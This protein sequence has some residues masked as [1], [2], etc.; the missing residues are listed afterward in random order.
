MG[1]KIDERLP[2]DFGLKV[3]PGHASVKSPWE[4][5]YGFRETVHYSCR[6]DSVVSALIMQAFRI[7]LPDYMER[8]EFMCDA[9]HNTQLA[10]NPSFLE[11]THT[12]PFFRGNFT[13]ALPADCG[14]ENSLMCGRVNDFGS[15]RVEKELDVCD[16]DIVGTEICRSTIYGMQGGSDACAEHFKAGPKLEFHMVE[17]KGCGDRHCRVVAESREKWPMPKKPEKRNHFG[18]IATADMI[19]FTPDED[20]LK[21]PQFFRGECDYRFTN[22]TNAEYDESS[23][24][25]Y[26]PATFII[27]PA[28]MNAI[29]KGVI[30][31]KDFDHTLKC[32]CEASGKAMFSDFFAKEGLRNWLGVP[33]EIGDDDGR[34]LGAYIEMYIQAKHAKYEIEAFNRDEVIY[35]ID[36][37]VV[38]SGNPKY[39]DALIAYWYGMSKTLINAQWALWEED[40][41]KDRL[42]LK[43]AKKI[44]KFC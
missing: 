42:R 37:G 13:G 38:S 28:I 7:V 5:L 33:R 20:C 36:R 40:S 19:K 29:E 12:H 1:K 2:Q 31:E 21:E 10:F 6:Y 34:V 24:V 3:L 44:D 11:K 17:A 25:T 14:D 26:P 22:G 8:T 43:I 9:S 35:V 32:V 39:L 15:Y 16:W 23:M 4:K 27:I 18:P 41:P 30:K